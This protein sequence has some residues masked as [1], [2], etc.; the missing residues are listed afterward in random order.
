MVLEHE[1]ENW[2]KEEVMVEV[3]TSVPTDIYDNVV[4]RCKNLNLTKA[5]YL[6]LLI[7]LD[8]DV[9]KYQKLVQYI[10]ILYNDI[11]SKQE[12]LKLQVTPVYPL[13]LEPN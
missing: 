5:E 3:K 11:V 4:K 1:K 12:A 10:Y 7:S 8:I 13:L 9:Q 2:R 6:R